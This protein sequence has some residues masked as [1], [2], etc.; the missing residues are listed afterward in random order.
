MYNIDLEVLGT[1]V[2]IDFG[3]M[4]PDSEA[5]CERVKEVLP[6]LAALISVDSAW[7]SLTDDSRHLR[8]LAAMAMEMKSQTAILAAK[9][10]VDLQIEIIKG[11]QS[12]ADHGFPEF[13]DAQNHDY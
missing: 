7:Q 9:A 12:I 2:V 3:S 5:L 13:A 4:E 1:K 8:A 11:N 6:I 10:Q